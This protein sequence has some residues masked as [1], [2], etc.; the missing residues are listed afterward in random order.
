MSGFGKKR[1]RDVDEYIALAPMEVQDKLRE[2][3][4]AIR[5]A[6]P[7]AV[8][9]ISYGMAYYEYRGRLAWFGLAK[10]H[11]GL[12]LRPP[13][14]QEHMKELV[15]YETTKSAIRLPLDKKIPVTLVKKLV[16]ARVKKNE[17]EK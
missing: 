7:A 17:A 16:K 8:E 11:I 6:A 5:E 2:V 13:V 12:Y 1:P 4:A 10:N 15:G 14:I 9:S 3:R